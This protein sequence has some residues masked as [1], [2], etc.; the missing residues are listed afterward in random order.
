MELYKLLSASDL[1]YGVLI[2]RSIVMD[3]K[4]GLVLEQHGKW[5]HSQEVFFNALNS[6]DAGEI[7]NVPPKE[8]EMWEEHFEDAA[9]RLQQWEFLREYAKKR[10]M[11]VLLAESCWKLGDWS[12]LKQVFRDFA[13]SQDDPKIKIFQSLLA[14][15]DAQ[16]TEVDTLCKQAMNILVTRWNIRPKIPSIAHA[17]LLVA[18]QH[19]IELYESAKIV[20]EIS[21]GNRHT[22][23]PEIKQILKIWRERLPNQWDDI[24]IWTDLLTWRQHVFSLIE[25]PLGYHEKAWSINKFASI[26]REKGLVEVC[27]THLEKIEELPNIEIQEACKKL[28]EEVTCYLQMPEHY[29]T[30]LDIINAINLEFF[31]D[32][33][34]AEFLTLKGEFL[35]RL[36]FREEGNTAFATAVSIYE[37]SSSAWSAWGRYCDQR[38][39]EEEDEKL[40]ITWACYTISCYMQ[41]IKHDTVSTSKRLLARVLWLLSFDKPYGDI[42]P[43]KEKAGEYTPPA[44]RRRTARGAVKVREV[45]EKEEGEGGKP[46]QNTMVLGMH[47]EKHA[48]GLPDWLYVPWIPQLLLALE[49][50]HGKQMKKLLSRIAFTFPQALYYPLNSYIKEREILLQRDKYLKEK[51]KKGKRTPLPPDEAL[52]LANE[53]MEELKKSRTAL[54]SDLERIT[55]EIGKNLREIG[56]AHV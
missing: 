14:L 18:F 7:V 36:G 12:G 6:Q 10:K 47:F 41:A 55:E 32:Q 8:K 46:D 44:K 28:K 30:G 21:G 13:I 23:L 4:A 43:D 34:K 17:P 38:F 5:N 2:G 53:V 48:E 20:K 50:P 49:R 15:K 27:L 56:R 54:T 52:D 31:G 51:G 19:I 24:S 45:K 1:Y 37:M 33:Q 39:E 9:K 42:H 35:T 25:N 16:I 40:R 29:R 22:K 11:P 3:S 26:A